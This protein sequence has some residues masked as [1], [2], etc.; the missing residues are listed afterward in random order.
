MKKINFDNTVAELRKAGLCCAQITVTAG[1]TIRGEENPQL[2]RSV[3]TLCSGMHRQKICGALTGGAIMLGL[4]ESPKTNL[5]VR[6][7]GDWFES[8]FGTSVC[9]EL[10]AKRREDERYSCGNLIRAS[11]QKCQDILAENGLID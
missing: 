4:W 9:A 6:E 10:I 7:L 11:V 2:V 1:L 8:E 3:R 5:M